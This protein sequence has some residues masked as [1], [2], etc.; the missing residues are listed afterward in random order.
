MGFILDAGPR[1]G[2]AEEAGSASVTLRADEA[3]GQV[4]SY[5]LVTM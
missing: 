1:G 2:G 5:L 4:H 3:S